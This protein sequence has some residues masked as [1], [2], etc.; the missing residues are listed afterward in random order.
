MSE[1]LVSHVVPIHIRSGPV[2][3]LE[4]RANIVVP[5][6]EPSTEKLEF[7]RVWCGQ[8]VVQTVRFHN[9]RELPCE[10]SI[11]KKNDSSLWDNFICEP[12]KGSLPVHLVSPFALIP[13]SLVCLSV[14]IDPSWRERL[15]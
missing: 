10:W 15:P 4:L 13:D 11:V 12:E 1:G 8:C 7:G 9:P 6:L 14:R 2:V 5:T 3:E